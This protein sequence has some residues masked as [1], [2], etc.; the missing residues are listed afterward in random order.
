MDMQNQQMNPLTPE[1]KKSSKMIWVIV[2]V[3]IVI[4]IAVV[5]WMWGGTVNVPSE[6]PEGVSPEVSGEIPEA[7]EDTTPVI[8]QELESINDVDLEKEL[9]GINADINNL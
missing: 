9:E 3:V 8:N 5:W 7:L 2:A 4:V 6:T 1:V